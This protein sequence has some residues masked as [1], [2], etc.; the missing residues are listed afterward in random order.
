MNTEKE[1]EAKILE[2]SHKDLEEKLI[3]LGAKFDSDQELVAYWL[4]NI[5]WNRLRV[6]KEWSKVIIEHKDFLEGG[7]FSKQA[8]E[9]WYETNDLESVLSVFQKIWLKI[10]SESTKRRVSYIIE[11]DPTFWKV[12]FDF[13]TY[14]SID[15]K[16]VNIPEFLEIEA[17]TEA[18]ILD[19][20]SSLNIN[21]EDLKNWTLVE[22]MKHYN[23]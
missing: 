8:Q 4:E 7:S 2:I 3:S 11:N 9:T 17:A 16:T 6:R 21:K 5:N 13:D 20:A 22:L 18:F 12:K 15:W 19:I 10:I 14:T 23:I 1:V